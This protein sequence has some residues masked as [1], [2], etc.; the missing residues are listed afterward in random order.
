MALTK[1]C[2]QKIG[3]AVLPPGNVVTANTNIRLNL[4]AEINTV[5][6][7]IRMFLL[8]ENQAFYEAAANSIHFI[9]VMM[10]HESI[11]SLVT[12]HVGNA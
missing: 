6:G 11:T 2:C 8:G 5:F 12:K 9:H 1:K 3:S 4:L 10:N 7:I